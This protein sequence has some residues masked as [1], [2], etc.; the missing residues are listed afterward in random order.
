MPVY[1]GGN[2]EFQALLKK[3]DKDLAVYLNDDQK[4]VYV[5]MEFI[6]DD[7]GKVIN[8]KII[9][10]GNDEINEKLLDIFEAMPRWTPAIRLEKY[11]PI[12]LKQTIIIDANTAVQPAS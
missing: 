6:I 7:Q 1:P 11:V 2:E 5:L 8:P 4:T 9:R 12:K 10:G 3:I